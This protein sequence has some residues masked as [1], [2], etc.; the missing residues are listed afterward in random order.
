MAYSYSPSRFG[1]HLKP[2]A[3]S[4]CWLMRL[5]LFST[6][7]LFFALLSLM[8]REVLPLDLSRKISQYGHNMWRIQD[9]YLPGIPVDIAQTK[10]GYLWIGTEGGLLR[11]DGVRFV[12]WVPPNGQQLPDFQILSLLS[13]SDGSLW[14]GTAKGLARWKE[15]ELTVYKDLPNRTNAIVEDPQGNIWIARSQMPQKRA[16]LCRVRGSDVHCFGTEEGVPLPAATRLVLDNSGNFWLSGHAGLCKWKDGVSTT[17]FQ[18]ELEQQGSLIGVFTL[19]VENENHAWIGIQQPDGHLELR[20]FDHGRWQAHPLPMAQGLP[21]SASAL[22]IDHQGALWIGTGSDGIYRLSGQTTDH[23]S[24][25]DGLSSDAILRF[26]QDREGLLWVASSKG[27]DSFRDLPVVSFSI[28]EGLVSDTVSTV[29]ASHNGGVWIGGA[30]ALGFI[31]DNKLSA[32]RTKD[33]FPGRDITTMFEDPS[34]RLWIGVDSNLYL[35]DDQRHFLPIHRPDGTPL[36]IIFAITEDSSGN[37]WVLTD[38]PSL[39]RIVNLKVQQE[40]KLDKIAHSIA[41][42]PI[43]G[44][45]L[46]FGNGDLAHYFSDRS[47]SFPADPAVSISKIRTLLPESGGRL[48]AVT[49]DGLIWWAGNKRAILT[50]RNALPCNELYAAVKD[51]DGTLWLYSRCGLLSIAAS[52]LTLW[53]KDSSAQVKV[54]ALD[55]Y[56]GVQAGVVPLQPQASRSLDGHLWFANDS[57]LQTFD[58]QTRR[59]N[60]LPPNVVVERVAANGV[61]YAPRDGIKLPP[62]IRNLELDYTA[63]SFVVPQKVR[64]LYKLEGHDNEWQDSQGRRQAFYS[65]LPPGPYRFRVTACNNSGVWNEAGT[66]LD[67]SVAPAYYQTTWFRLSCAAAFLLLLWGVYQLRLRQVTQHVRQ[68][69][70]G[71][72]EERERIARELHDTLLQSFQGVLLYFQGAVRLLPDRPDVARAKAKLQEAIEIAAQAIAE[73]R[74]A[75]QG[76]RS[77]AADTSDLATSLQVLARELASNESGQNPPD[78]AVQVEGSPRDLHPILRDEVYRI[79]GEALRNAFRH[80]HARRIEVEIHYDLQHLRLRVRDDGKGIDSKIVS[81][82]GRPGHYGLRGMGERAKAIGGNFELWSNLD[83]GTEIELSIP[84]DA[85][86]SASPAPRRS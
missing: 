13:A 64:F 41:A 56:H 52:E 9:G 70:Q 11:F 2:T 58:P 49:Q 59:A 53:Q 86:Y 38:A 66:F 36:G 84:A 34:G 60:T 75:I 16:P 24:S 46:G 7:V 74:D 10:D 77:P 47:E 51:T 80:A 48:W 26:F 83:S 3:T 55:V 29:L 14:I 27:I 21:P 37:E 44:V 67:F 32:I 15:G 12:P 40:I 35:M 19:A 22:F 1:A 5:R 76:L 42:D 50:T 57:I 8:S 43:Q 82:Q 71:R 17:Y 81:D 85:A 79:A 39:V 72:F 6:S 45:W 69:M 20:E 73:G 23:F 33:G 62:L 4:A 25:A 31:K 63:L 30:E 54:A 68:R 78:F 61:S 65:G 28:R 18:K